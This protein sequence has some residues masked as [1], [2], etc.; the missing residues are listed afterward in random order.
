MHCRTNLMMNSHNPESMSEVLK[1]IPFQ[2]SFATFIDETVEFADIVLPDSHDFERWDLFPAND[3]YAFIAPGPGEWYWLM[4]QQSVTPPGQARPWTE[5]YLDLAERIGILPKLLEEGNRIWNLNEEHKL[6][7]S[8]KYSIKDI[9][10]KQAKSLIGNHFSFDQLNESACL[11]TRAIT[12]QEAYPR[13][14]IKARVPVYLEHL[15]QTGKE[16]EKIINQLGIE[17]DLKPYTPLLEYF[18]C[19]ATISDEDDFD[20]QIVNFKVPFITFSVTSENLWINE[21]SE[22][23]PYTTM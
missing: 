2:V 1:N 19:H 11:I 8:K 14:F 17:W 15:L 18:P 4:R 10:E 23:N 6:D 20:L 22:A 13:P 3:P 5:V 16:V 12:I 9:A 7:S 21:I